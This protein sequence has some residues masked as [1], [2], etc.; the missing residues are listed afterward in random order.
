MTAWIDLKDSVLSEKVN[1]LTANRVVISRGKG[2][3]ED[4][5]DDKGVAQGRSLW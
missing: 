1:L 2:W 4:E 3:W 5:W